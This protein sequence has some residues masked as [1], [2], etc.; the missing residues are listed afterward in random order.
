MKLFSFLALAMATVFTCTIV[1][2]LQAQASESPQLTVITETTAP[3]ENFED[4]LFTLVNED[5]ARY[6]LPAYVLDELVDTA[7]E[8]RIGELEE[9]FSHIRNGGNCYSSILAETG[10][11]YTAAAEILAFGQTNP[12]SVL[13]AWYKSPDHRN[14]ILS[15]KYTKIG[16]A[17]NRSI[18]G[19]NFWEILFIAE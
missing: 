9:N 1:N 7:S 2:P 3:T 18:N 13:E 8:I 4:T 17:H 6:G 5:R 19:I 16:I 14:C 12:K 10:I 11:S 15:D